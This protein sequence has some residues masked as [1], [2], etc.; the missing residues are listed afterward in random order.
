MR[1]KRMLT[2]IPAEVLELIVCSLEY[3]SLMNV[4]QTNHYFHNLITS[5]HIKH[6]LLEL[7]R[8]AARSGRPL[9]SFKE[10]I[11]EGQWSMLSTHLPCY[12]CLVAL[13]AQRYFLT[14]QRTAKFA[15]GESAAPRRRCTGCMYNQRVKGLENSELFYS[16]GN[17]WIECV[18]CKQT[19]CY[20]F[21]ETRQLEWSN[22]A[23]V[24]GRCCFDCYWANRGGNSGEVRLV[25]YE[26]EGQKRAFL[27]V[28]IQREELKGI[29]YS[30]EL[31]L[32]EREVP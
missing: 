18:G 5:E 25:P 20:S 14:S 23:W 27:E 15:L 22:I 28:P 7:E 4:S 24:R 16:E 3:F 6:A 31:G 29:L 9:D 17:T 19:K 1:T 11:P 2:D 8:R 13:P 26:L 32:N 12:I 10:D 30:H 21:A